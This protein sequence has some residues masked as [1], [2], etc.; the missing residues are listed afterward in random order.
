MHKGLD[1]YTGTAHFQSQRMHQNAGFCIENIQQKI[2]DRDPRSPT[3]KGRHLF[4]LT[5]VPTCQ[6]L[7]PL[8][9]F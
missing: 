5:P 4:A 8:R 3:S 6:K 9:I 7:V 2:R 1:K